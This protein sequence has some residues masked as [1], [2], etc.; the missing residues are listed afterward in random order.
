MVAFVADKV[1][2]LYKCMKFV[3]ECLSF[4]EIWKDLRP[5]KRAPGPTG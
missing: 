4:K 1:D 2:F 5:T 3:S